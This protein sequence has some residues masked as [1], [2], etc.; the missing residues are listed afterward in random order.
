VQRGNIPPVLQ[1]FDYGDATTSSEGRP[2]T[3][4]APQAL[5]MLNSRFVLDQAGG[6]ARRLLD[7][8]AL[9]DAQRVER[10]YLTALGRPPEGAETDSALAYV[11]GLEKRLDPP[12]ARL[13]AWRS[14][15]HVLMSRN[16]FLYLN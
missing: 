1:A 5:F 9:S 2:R 6:F 3:N 10:A 11:S 16:E 12:E 7:D 8:A 13:T 15:C 14:F 4:V